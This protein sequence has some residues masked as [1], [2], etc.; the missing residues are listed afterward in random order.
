MEQ[1]LNLIEEVKSDFEHWRVTRAKRGKIPDYLW[2][3]VKILMD[4]H[5][6]LTTITQSLSINTNQ[7]SQRFNLHNQV[8]F[9]EVCTDAAAKTSL[10]LPHE[11]VAVVNDNKTCSIELHRSNG[12]TLKI[13]DYPIESLPMIIA[14]F[15]G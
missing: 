9:V 15:I 12:G 11:T 5:Y 6:P 1:K 7:I 8:N 4:H 13:S 3:K 2:E 14:Q 10:I